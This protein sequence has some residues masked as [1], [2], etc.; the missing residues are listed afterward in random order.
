MPM[1]IS[2]VGHRISRCTRLLR[3]RPVGTG[4]CLTGDTSTGRPVCSPSQSAQSCAQW[5]MPCCTM[6]RGMLHILHAVRRVALRVGHA[7]VGARDVDGVN[8][9]ER[10]VTARELRDETRLKRY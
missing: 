7:S 2:S 6:G 5:S 3:V 8:E 4:H 1:W 9:R 10:V